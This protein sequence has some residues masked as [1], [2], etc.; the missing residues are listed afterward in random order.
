V[1]KSRG[2]G[3]GG[4]R[5]GAGRKPKP[6]AKPLDLL[7]PLIGADPDQVMEMSMRVLASAGA[8]KDA[9]RIAYM[10]ARTRANSAGAAGKK[11]RAQKAAETAGQNSDWGADLIP[12][13]STRN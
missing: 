11:Q 5:S 3:R 2:I 10:L 8:L 13:T 6:P 4:R 1:T 7:G 12:P 9:S